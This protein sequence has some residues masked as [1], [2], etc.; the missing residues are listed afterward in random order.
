MKNE[1]ERRLCKIRTTAS[2][3]PR[4]SHQDASSSPTSISTMLSSTLPSLPAFPLPLKASCPT[5]RSSTSSPPFLPFNMT[6]HFIILLLFFSLTSLPVLPVDALTQY[7]EQSPHKNLTIARGSSITIPCK[8]RNRQGECLWIHDGKGIGIIRGKYEFRR[9]PDNGDCGLTIYDV[10]PDYDNGEWQCQVTAAAVN[11]QTLQS[12]VIRL[13][14]LISPRLLNISSTVSV[15]TGSPSR[16][17]CNYEGDPKPTIRWYHINPRSGETSYVPN[18]G[19]EESVLHIL[20]T[21]YSHEGEYFCRTYRK[22]SRLIFLHQDT[23]N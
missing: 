3:D 23:D 20:N 17:Y 1:Q 2:E 13:I 15:P 4:S 18:N 8:V 12:E 19:P 16:L 21:T 22:G 10:S 11:Q 6:S 7:F 5:T 14:V 9:A